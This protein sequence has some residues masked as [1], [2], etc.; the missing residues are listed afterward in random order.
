MGID[1]L[2][3][4]CEQLAKRAFPERLRSDG[5]HFRVQTQPAS[6]E[7]FIRLAFDLAR[8]NAKGDHAVLCRLLR[9]LVLIGNHVNTEQRLPV[10]RDQIDLLMDQ[11]DK[12]LATPY[13][14]QQVW[15]VYQELKQN[16]FSANSHSLIMSDH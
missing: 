8:V 7:D 9:A 3:T 6:F 4:I 1:H 16:W 10:I 5:D 15:L 2:G 14:K 13:E 11:T 12:T